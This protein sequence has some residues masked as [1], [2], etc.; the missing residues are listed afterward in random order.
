M[1][2]KP[3]P[4]WHVPLLLIGATM[5]LPLA[6]MLVT[7]LAEPGRSMQAA[8]SLLDFV[9][10]ATWHWENF[11]EVGRVIPFA[12]FYT[13]S[14]V[15]AGVVTA[16]LV[17]TSASSAYAFSRLEWRGRD[18]VFKAYIATMMVP[19]AVTMLPNFVAMKMLPDVLV[20]AIPWIDW[21][22]PRVVGTTLQDPL[23]GRLVGIDSY[24]ALI[25]PVM[26]SAYGTFMLRQFFISIPRDIDE[27]AEIDGAGHWIIFSRM[28]LPLALPA[29]ATLTVFTFLGTWGSFLWPLIVT[30]RLELATLPLGLL[31]FQNT[32]TYGTDWHLLMAAALLILLPVVLLFIVGQ[33]FFVSG[34]T[35]GAVKG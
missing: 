18:M 26:F 25:V 20:R 22:T 31:A 1:R 23:V 2:R 17:L 35:G 28:I 32:G 5:L 11:T 13:N 24:F 16:G 3:S 15:V 21:L 7:A 34:L 29:L 33:R 6:F 27:A 14:L 9:V 19:G 30:N 10:P 12:R 8:N 4:F